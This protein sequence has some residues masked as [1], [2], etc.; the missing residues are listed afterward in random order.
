MDQQFKTKHDI[1]FAQSPTPDV[2]LERDAVGR[3]SILLS[4]GS[5]M[6]G[7]AVARALDGRGKRILR[8]VRKVSGATASNELVWN[9][10]S[11]K[12][13]TSRL[14]EFGPLGAA[15]HF[16]G[17][18]VSAKRW[19]PGYKREITESR[20]ASTRLLAEGLARLPVPPGVLLSASATGIYGDR[21]DE[22]L[23]EDSPA[24]RGFLADLCVQWEAA[25]RPAEEAGIRVVHLRFGVAI[26]RDG[27]AMAKL[28]PLFRMGLG[29][30]LGSG[31][32]WM[33]WVSETDAVKAAIF[34]MDHAELSGAVNV[35]APNPVTN[36]EFTRELGRALRRPAILPAPAFALRLA[37]GEMADEALLASTRAVPKRLPAAGFAFTHPTIAEAFRDAVRPSRS[38][39]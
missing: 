18:N 39:N 31:R 12:W 28:L 35:T 13:D 32:Q 15:I 3:D 2:P 17:A 27:G 11:G 9:P 33:N 21:G 6:L 22:T 14:A 1:E 24:G 5:G 4:G 37:V 23:D 20:I 38:I 19:T 30:R 29:G 10:Q 36:A 7:T 25:T 34:A 16:S 26:G 8:L